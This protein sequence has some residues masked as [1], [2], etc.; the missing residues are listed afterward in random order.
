MSFD[1]D[2]HL[3]QL[4][5]FRHHLHEIAEISGE[6]EKTAQTITDFLKEKA[7]PDDLHTGLGGRG[8]AATYCG[9]EEGLHLLIRCELDGL[10]IQDNINAEYQSKTDGTGHKCGHDGH[11]AILCGVAMKLAAERPARGK[12]TLLLQP[13]EE[14]GQGAQRVLEDEEFKKLQPDCCFALH[15]LPGFS[16]SAII[17]REGTFAAASVGLEVNLTGTTAHAAHPEEGRSPALAVAQLIESFSAVPQFYSSLDQAV[18]VTV[19]NAQL[20][21]KAFGTSPG[22]AVVRATLRT[23]DDDHLEEIKKRCLQLTEQISETYGLNMDYHW[24]EEFTAT[25]SGEE[26]VQLIRKVAEIRNFEIQVKET[27]FSWSEDFG[28]F[29]KKIGGA[30]FGLGAGKDQ[31]AL[32]AETY[33]FPDDIIPTG[34]AM[35]TGIIDELTG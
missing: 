32:H 29:T 35:F 23:Y 28:R 27:P 17:L 9:D 6:E 26:A 10:P 12:V 19:I 22:E 30:M 18:K 21:Q 34:I 7:I 11:M 16:K 25:R 13:A 2:S 14:T 1:I 33:D 20:G 3:T 31:P 24:V 8:I 4:K 5:D 15:N